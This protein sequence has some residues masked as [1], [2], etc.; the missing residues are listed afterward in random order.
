MTRYERFL[1][2]I[3]TPEKLERLLFGINEYDNFF[4]ELF[5]INYCHEDCKEMQIEDC[6]L[7]EEKCRKCKLKYLNENIEAK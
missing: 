1:E 5:G 7:D 3:N 6:E 2:S 4:D